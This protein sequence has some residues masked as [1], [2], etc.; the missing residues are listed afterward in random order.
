MSVLWQVVTEGVNQTNR[1]NYVKD[2]LTID[3]LDKSCY[4]S[5]V[6]QRRMTYGRTK[7]HGERCDVPRAR[8]SLVIRQE[9]YITTKS[10]RVLSGSKNLRLLLLV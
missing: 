9:S 4:C 6:P 3:K 8:I 10:G 1:S 7:R 5:S 2:K